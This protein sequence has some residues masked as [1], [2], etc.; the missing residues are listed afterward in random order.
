MSYIY[1]VKH[2][3][4]AGAKGAQMSVLQETASSTS[5]S[6]TSSTAKYTGPPV[7]IVRGEYWPGRI[8]FD[9]LCDIK[10]SISVLNLAW[11]LL[12]NT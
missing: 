11:R 8:P 1:H 12:S 7:R 5:S 4:R 2:A 3:W 6:S 10:V 9:F